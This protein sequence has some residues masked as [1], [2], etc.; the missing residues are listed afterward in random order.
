MGI[1]YENSLVAFIV[2]TLFLGGGAA[3]LTGRAQASRWKSIPVLVFYIL[4]LT[5]AVRFFHFALYE[6]VLLSLYYYILNFVILLA[7]ALFGFRLTR[8]R[9]MVRQYPFLYERAG[10]LGWREKG[11]SQ[12]EAS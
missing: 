10:L 8:A 6:G 11:G 2:V 4:L 7:F 12:E 5:C 1:L 9:Q 3:Y